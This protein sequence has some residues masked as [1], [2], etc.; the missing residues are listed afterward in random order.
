M[1][2]RKELLSVSYHSDDDT[3]MHHIGEVD[4]GVSRW[5]KP[6]IERYGYDGVK[7]IL[8]TLGHLAW[9]VKTCFFEIQ[10][11]TA[12]LEAIQDNARQDNGTGALPYCK[13]TKED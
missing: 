4:F 5:L 12:R 2:E 10:N 6:Y 1:S 13:K 9:E 3:G 7:E 11:K 8:A